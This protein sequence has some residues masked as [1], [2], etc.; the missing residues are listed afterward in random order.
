M[1]IFSNNKYFAILRDR[2]T[3]ACPLSLYALAVFESGWDIHVLYIVQQTHKL[4]VMQL[5]TKRACAVK[6]GL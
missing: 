3:V 2:L 5:N 4:D 1:F 6:S